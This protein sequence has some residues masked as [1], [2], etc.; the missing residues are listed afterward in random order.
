VS[1]HPQSDSESDPEE[2]KVVEHIVTTKSTIKVEKQ[3]SSSE[4]EQAQEA[5]DDNA[6]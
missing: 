5:E 2:A 3:E 4:E 1:N 6:E